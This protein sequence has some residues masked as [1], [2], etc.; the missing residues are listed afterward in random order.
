M[1]LIPPF[2]GRRVSEFGRGEPSRVTRGDAAAALEAIA[3]ARIGGCFWG[4]QPALP[5]GCWTL[6]KSAK[7][8]QVERANAP[9]LPPLHLTNDV[10]P[11]PLF[12][13]A[14]QVHCHADDETALL[15]AVA[16]C[17]VITEGNGRYAPLS[18]TAG[19][20]TLIADLLR[21]HILEPASFLDPFTGA[22]LP[23]IALVGLLAHWRQLIDSNRQIACA[24]GMAFWKRETVEPLLWSG[25][26]VEFAR[27]A[28]G[29]AKN[30]FAAIWRSRLSPQD[31]A[32]LAKSG[33]RE[34]EVEDGFIRSAGLGADCV[35]P[36]SIV[37]DAEGIYFNPAKP[38]ALET[39]LSHHAF[40]SALLAQAASLRETIVAAGLSKYAQRSERA[41][42]P[43]G[44]REHV[45]VTGQVEDDRS[46]LEGGGDVKGNLD[47]LQRARASSPE[48]F[49]IY[50]SH[51]DVDAG[52]RA[53]H[54]PDTAVLEHA[55]LIV[56]DAGISHVL[57]MVD[58]LHVLTSL[59]GFEGLIRGKKV[60]THGVPFYAGWG[61]TT[62]LGSVPARR[63]RRLTIDELVAGALLVYPRYLDPETGLPCTA[64]TLV[65]RLVGGSTRHNPLI[66][67]ARRLQ[68]KASHAVKRIGGRS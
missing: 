41:K 45:L 1:F 22:P 26:Q 15:A 24:L 21:T 20:R 23:P 40:D 58:S 60:T 67:T 43:G 28:D 49:L 64:H 38:S 12:D 55:D 62:D 34:V 33:C 29:L 36:L 63:A 9:A 53:G 6:Y 27:P 11:W 48:A 65:S 13:R 59:A 17:T 42:R 18:D 19:D 57:D 61:L 8:W 54:V 47:L 7:G 52:H 46:V 50:K 35:P 44:R 66:V 68:G 31:L 39:I 14:T 30:D 56:R 2:P 37:V 5:Q 10:D 32:A 16:G 4:T 51:P 3:T 25:R